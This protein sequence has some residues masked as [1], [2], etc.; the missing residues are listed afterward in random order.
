MDKIISN[1]LEFNEVQIAPNVTESNYVFTD[2]NGNRQVM[3]L[4]NVH[5]NDKNLNIE[6]GLPD[7]KDDFGFQTVL[8]QAKKASKNAHQVI[9]S[10]NG[11]FYDMSTGQ[12]IGLT[13]K[14]GKFLNEGF[15][16]AFGISA[17]SVLPP[18]SNIFPFQ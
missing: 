9:A 1:I 8:E 7:N 5:L 17:C 12:P 4:I 10:V 18:N 11:D 2:Y 14:N 15:N 16:N 13:I 3:Y 6:I